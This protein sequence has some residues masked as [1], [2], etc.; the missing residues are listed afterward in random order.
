MTDQPKAERSADAKAR[1]KP[2]V[3]AGKTKSGRQKNRPTRDRLI[4]AAIDNAQVLSTGNEEDLDHAPA[5]GDEAPASRKRAKKVAPHEPHTADDGDYRVETINRDYALVLMG[6]RAIVIKEIA[7]GPIDDRQRVLTVEAFC[8]WL[9][10]RFLEIRSVDGKVRVVTWGKAW[11]NDRHRRQYEGV[12]FA[13]DPNNAAATPGY[14]NLWRG[15]AVRPKPKANGYKTFRDH[16]LVNICSGDES[17]FTWVFGFF[18]QI[19]QRPRERVGVALVLCGKPGTGKTIVGEVFGSLFP[20]HYLRST[21]RVTSPAISTH[22]WPRAYCSR[23]KKPFVQATRW[24]K[25]E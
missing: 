2:R 21:T 16:L 5:A 6:S 3:A 15:F 1:T 23:S 14:L 18:S 7:T 9:G 22:T 13:P 10:N 19:V 17:L 25:G 8:I 20:S 24:P 11:L 4:D 12:E